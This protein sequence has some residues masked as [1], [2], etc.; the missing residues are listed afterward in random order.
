M[1]LFPTCLICSLQ[2]LSSLATT[3]VMAMKTEESPT[4]P[5][6]QSATPTQTYAAPQWA[7]TRMS[8]FHSI[9]LTSPQLHSQ[10]YLST[11]FFNNNHSNLKPHLAT[12]PE[13]YVHTGPQ[14]PPRTNIIKLI[15]PIIHRQRMR[16]THM[17]LNK[18]ST[19]LLWQQD[20]RLPKRNNLRVVAWTR[21]TLP[22]STM[23]WEAQV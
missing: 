6:S 11:Q 15:H 18:H 19:N 16:I 8:S 10:K 20:S 21:L 23:H 1:F 2:A 17:P 3:I 12:I 14:Q 22:P 9:S 5:L 4:A 13:S 7:T